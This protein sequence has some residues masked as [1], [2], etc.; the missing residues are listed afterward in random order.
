MSMQSELVLG[1]MDDF[2]FGGHR[3]IVASDVLTVVNKGKER[4]LGLH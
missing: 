1:F 4:S 2:T 3:A